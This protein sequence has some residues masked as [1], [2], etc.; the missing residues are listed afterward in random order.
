MTK[1]L[2]EPVYGLDVWLSGECSLLFQRTSIWFPILPSGGWKVP[3]TLAPG[4]PMPSYSLF[5]HTYG[6]CMGDTQMYMHTHTYILKLH[7]GG[8][9]VSGEETRK[10]DNI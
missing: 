5:E 4:N 2:K 7:G 6:L 10:E 3:I 1:F 9:G 8:W